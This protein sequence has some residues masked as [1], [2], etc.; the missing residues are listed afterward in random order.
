MNII[1]ETKEIYEQFSDRVK[2]EILC[3]TGYKDQDVIN[4][5]EVEVS[6]V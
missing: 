5:T 3:R 4:D 1:E 6:D 2:Y